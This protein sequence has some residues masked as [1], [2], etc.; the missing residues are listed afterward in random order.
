MGEVRG[1]STNTNPSELVLQIGCCGVQSG[2]D[3]I[4]PAMRLFENTADTISG[5]S[6]GEL[7]S[8]KPEQT[9]TSHDLH[10]PTK[11]SNLMGDRPLQLATQIKT[12]RITTCSRSQEGEGGPKADYLSDICQGEGGS[13]R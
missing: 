9:T 6:P 11:N 12:G 1:C 5:L 4:Y 10:M 3:I 8:A 2:Q 7:S 13:S